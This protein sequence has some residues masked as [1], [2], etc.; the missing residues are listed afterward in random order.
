MHLVGRDIIQQAQRKFDNKALSK[1]LNKWVQAVE[2]AQ[3][4]TPVDIRDTWRSADP[5]H[6]HY[7]F[8]V[9]WN[10]YRLVAIVNLPAQT[11]VVIDVMTHKEYDKWCRRMST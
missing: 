2:Q 9:V 10:E 11:V 1:A 4:K 6:G 7:V 3:W 8:D 5:A